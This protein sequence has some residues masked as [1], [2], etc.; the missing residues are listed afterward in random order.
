V[1][2]RIVSLKD[3]K[4]KIK[5][6]IVNNSVYKLIMGR[7]L[8]ETAIKSY[9]I[10]ISKSKKIDIE[11]LTENYHEYLKNIAID[12]H[13]E[14]MYNYFRTETVREFYI[15]KLAVLTDS[16]L[17]A[18][19]ADYKTFS[20]VKDSAKKREA[21]KQFPLLLQETFDLGYTP[22]LSS[23][24]KD[25]HNILS[26]VTEH[27]AIRLCNIFVPTSKII[28]EINGKSKTHIKLLM[29][30]KN[31]NVEII[32]SS[33]ELTKSERLSNVF[34]DYGFIIDSPRASKISKYIADFML[35]NQYKIK[36]EVGRLQTGWNKGVFFL[37]QRE[38]DVVWLESDLKKAY[39]QKGTY[40]NQLLLLKELAKGKV[41]INV[42]GAFAST[43]FGIVNPMNFFI[44]NGGLT[45]GGKSLAVK[46][47][48]SFFGKPSRMG[49]NWNAT[50]NGLETYW[51]QNHS[52]PMWIDEMEV[53]SKVENIIEAVYEFT[54]GHGKT[55][56]YS[57]DGEV[58]KRETK[59]FKGICFT[60]G[61]KSF[62]E[63]QNLAK[64]RAKPRG[65]TRRVLDLNIKELW[66]NVDLEK[67]KNLLDANYGILGVNFIE[68]LELNSKAIKDDYS[69]QISFFN[70]LVDGEKSNQF[71]ILKLTLE[72]M[73]RMD[74]VTEHEYDIQLANLKYFAKIESS[75]MKIIKDTYTEFKERYTEF[76]MANREHFDFVSTFSTVGENLHSKTPFYG[77]I[78]LEKNTISVFKNEFQKWCGDNNFV[79]D[80]VL[81]TLYEK[82]SLN[83]NKGRE[84]YKDVAVRFDKT[85][86]VYQFTNLFE[87]EVEII[88]EN[89]KPKEEKEVIIDENIGTDTPPDL[90]PAATGNLFENE[91]ITPIQN[92]KVELNTSVDI[93][94][95][96]IPF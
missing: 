9:L 64:D 32:E 4:I 26:F 46:C 65:V 85:I 20:K 3:L 77:K 51:E 27:E 16:T 58:K 60:T 39:I 78:N 10:K 86:K 12:E 94:N 25:E 2:V 50:L 48:L 93:D 74:L 30:Y 7:G 69:N 66:T 15:K 83:V 38:Q 72:I 14:I 68:Y 28:S 31:Q 92:Q 18:I 29:R 5:G 45:E 81:E 35:D 73:K 21:D 54:D 34:G 57:A 88:Y 71:G 23:A 41:F 59:E 43:L 96:E 62:S 13:F 1:V 6:T 53:S 56:A 91:N 95:D 19:K 11:V 89:L 75:N 8:S 42:L 82:K 55:R 33:R 49:N 52:L 44:H 61:E 67:V 80:Q 22:F 90:E 63:V 87:D 70:G 37:P 79:K 40:N 24:Y 47:A 17:R 84:N 76:I 36:D